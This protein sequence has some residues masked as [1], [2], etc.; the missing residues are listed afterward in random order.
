MPIYPTLPAEQ[1]G[2]ILTDSGAVAVFV[3]TAEQAA[4]IAE[5]RAELPA[6]RQVIA[7]DA[8][9]PGVDITL[10][11]LEA[12]GAALESPATLAQYKADALAVRPDDLATLIYTSGTTGDPKGVMLTHGNLCRTCSP[13]QAVIPSTATDVS[14]SFLP[15]CHIFERTAGTT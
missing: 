5:V 9:P 3:S 8:A 14:L 10:A 2:Y 12:R 13:S 4:K 11:A 7:F 1:V 6:L 15:L